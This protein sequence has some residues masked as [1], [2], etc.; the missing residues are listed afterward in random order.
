[1]DFASIA[2][3]KAAS[4]SASKRRRRGASALAARRYV[5]MH[6][7]KSRPESTSRRSVAHATDSARSG[8]TAKNK[9]ATAAPAR[10]AVSPAAG[11][12]AVST[13]LEIQ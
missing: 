2:T 12:A 5:R 13:R 3:A 6:V 11:A 8:W 1:M 7:R 4:E 9:A 10:S